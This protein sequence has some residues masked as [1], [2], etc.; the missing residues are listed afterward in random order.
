[1][2]EKLFWHMTKGPAKETPQALGFGLHGVCQTWKKSIKKTVM[3][4]QLHQGPR[5]HP[6]NTTLL[7]DSKIR[8][9]IAKSP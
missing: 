2:L 1:M 9:V 3:G 5:S 6:V 8:N 4:V 7:E